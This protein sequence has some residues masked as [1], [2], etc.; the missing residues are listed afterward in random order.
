MNR[1]AIVEDLLPLYVDDLLQ[2]E[3][4]QWVEEHL[5]QCPSCQTALAQM[6]EVITVDLPNPNEE[7]AKTIKKVTRQMKRYEFILVTLAFLLAMRTT[8]IPEL[9]FNGL[10]AYALLGGLLYAFYRTWLPPIVLS[11]VPSFLY[12]V[13]DDFGDASFTE[14]IISVA[15][16]G[17]I[18]T[19]LS[20]I[21]AFIAYAWIQALQKEEQ[22]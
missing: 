19:L 9:T 10:W 16:M 21:G 3:T 22:R 15:S 1:C 2:E 11:F 5:P 12:Y 14:I 7:A 20:L 6:E 8:I 17:T 18:Y 4:K 13:Q